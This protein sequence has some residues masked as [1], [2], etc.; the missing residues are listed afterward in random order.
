M[1]RPTDA[2][3]RL[4]YE[5]PVENL[6]NL[7]DR[8]AT[9]NRKAKRLGVEPASYVVLGHVTHERE[10]YKVID[11]VSHDT[12][13]SVRVCYAQI[14]VDGRPVV[15]NGWRFIATLQHV[16]EVDGNLVRVVPGV[17]LPV[18]YRSERPGCDHCRT[19]RKRND[20]YVVRHTETGDYRQVGSSCLRDFLGGADPHL[21]AATCEWLASL[22]IILDD[23]EAWELGQAGGGRSR[24]YVDL[25]EYL[26]WVAK[27]IRE[28]GWVSR[29]QARDDYT[30]MATCDTAWAG[31]DDFNRKR[32]GDP[33]R[34]E[35]PT[36][37]DAETAAAALEWARA[38]REKP[39]ASDFEYN[40]GVASSPDYLLPKCEGIIASA[41]A[42]YLREQERLNR[43]KVEA[44]L[45]N[46][47]AGAVG[48]KL[49]G[50]KAT[51]LSVR[52]TEGEWGTGECIKLVDAS[53]RMLV[54]WASKP[55][56]FGVDD[57][58]T[59]RGRIKACGEY[60]GL[61]ETVLTRCTIEAAKQE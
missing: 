11:G 19:V 14:A 3:G 18:H 39:S 52:T 22:T 59:V 45:T 13:K 37:A 35:K 34:P 51:V 33:D 17:E 24:A 61:R 40:L 1:T 21:A 60:R 47:W 12:G 28:V 38:M 46:E 7:D 54:W 43:A 8:L 58:V 2:T 49:K 31:M 57:V 41:V 48:D 55:Q 15:L 10:V 50:V 16:A 29:A 32:E 23:A 20:T 26:T 25:A 42:C 5:V 44:T 27:A 56:G 36:D 53:G 4:L 9:M 6:A 30:A